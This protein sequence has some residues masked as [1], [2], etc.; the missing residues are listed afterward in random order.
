MLF[1]ILKGAILFLPFYERMVFIMNLP[2]QKKWL[3]AFSFTSC[4]RIT[5]AVWVVLLAARG[6]SLWQIGL[7]EGIFHCVSLTCEIPSGMAADL[8]GRRRTLAFSGILGAAA[9]LCMAFSTNYAG[10]CLSMA[11]SALSFNFISGTQDAIVYDSLLATDA[12]DEYIR[13]NANCCQLENIGAAL[14][15]LASFLSAFLSFT[16]YYLLDACI[17]LSR[18]FTALRLAEPV[19]TAQQA[20]R[21]AYPFAGLCSRIKEHA[22]I[23]GRFLAHSPAAARLILADALLSLPGYLTLMFLQQRLSEL[24]LPT[25]W[26]GIPVLLVDL[27]R[28]AGTAVGAR[29]RPRSLLG[30]AAVCSAGLGLGTVFAGLGGIVPAVCGAMAAAAAMDAWVL[31]VQR[32]P[33]ELYPSDQRATLVSVNSMGYRVLMIAVSPLTGWVGDAAGSAG[34][35]LALLGGGLLL[36][37]LCAA[38]ALLRRARQGGR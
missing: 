8:M 22:V 35:G 18:T 31:H 36:G 26:L 6:Y 33:N 10:V 7:A 16:G 17:S 24:G 23:V 13:V 28:I 25:I 1:S 19:V 30:L 37:A 27:G 32:R 34:A 20:A 21:T 11:F 15:D 12:S 3:Y 9:A 38:L 29:I 2:R 4:L 5:D 14:S